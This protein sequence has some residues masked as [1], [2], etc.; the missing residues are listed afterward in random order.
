M[1]E[2]LQQLAKAQLDA[3]TAAS[4]VLT[5][6]PNIIATQPP[7]APGLSR[8]RILPIVKAPLNCCGSILT[9]HD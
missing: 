1:T 7:H 5:L 6:L 3:C 2:V 9:V 4:S 8:N